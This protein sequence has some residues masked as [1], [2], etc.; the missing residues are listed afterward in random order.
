MSMENAFRELAIASAQKQKIM[1]NDFIKK[2]AIWAGVPM[3]EAS[4]GSRNVF[5]ELKKVDSLM[6]L[7]G[8]DAPLS[9]VDTV[10]DLGYTDLAMFGGLMEVGED[11]A[12]KF[13]GKEKYFSSK[14]PLVLRQTASSFEK[15]LIYQSLRPY[16]KTLGKEI[17]AGG[18]TADKQYSL[19]CVKW[20][21][22]ETTGLYNPKMFG[23][24]K[25]FDLA[26][27]N[28]GNLYYV[29]DKVPGYGV[30][31]KA[32]FGLQLVGQNGASIV[33]I[34]LA[35][36]ATKDSGFKALP[37]ENQIDDM[38]YSVEGDMSDTV[39]YGHPRILGALAYYKRK[40]L[41][42]AP[43]DMSYPGQISDWAGIPLIG[44]YNFAFGTEAVVA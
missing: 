35:A 44:S 8:L 11:K 20:S 9:A 18:S 33:N 39:I 40:A 6:K 31:L 41:K 22:G 29:K 7:E 37:T 28:G 36:D 25:V 13:N 16:A 17:K 2:A 23:N 21:P 26:P 30:R 5:E 1:V 24:G 3:Q 43:G 14:L 42:M 4:H 15:A 34:D 19:V 38:I 27:M 32:N 10:T 12:Q